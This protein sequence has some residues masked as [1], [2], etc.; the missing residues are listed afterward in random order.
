[1][2]AATDGRAI[3]AAWRDHAGRPHLEVLEFRSGSDWLPGRVRAAVT[4]H[5]VAPAFDQIGANLDPA[6]T[7]TRLRVRTTPLA[8]RWMQ[9]ATLFS[10]PA[11]ALAKAAAFRY[12][13]LARHGLRDAASSCLNRAESRL[14]LLRSIWLLFFMRKSGAQWGCACVMRAV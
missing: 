12:G 7:L 8:L 13:F 4:K 6:D 10:V 9:A 3:V 5:R 1:M 2:I 14:V 11:P